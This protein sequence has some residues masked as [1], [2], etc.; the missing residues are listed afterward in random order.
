MIYGCLNYIEESDEVLI[1]GF[2][3]K[4]HAMGEI[5]E[6]KFKVV[7]MSGVSVL[8]RFKE[9]EEKPRP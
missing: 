4:G 6:V 9:K 1:G 3:H 2:G 5:P 7:K 8:A